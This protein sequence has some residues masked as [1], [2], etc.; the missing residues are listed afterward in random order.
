[1]VQNQSRA[2]Q[3]PQSHLKESDPERAVIRVMHSA[4]CHAGF[5]AFVRSVLSRRSPFCTSKAGRA[6]TT[7]PRRTL[8]VSA[9][10]RV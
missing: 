4:Q 1:M 6:P 5:V 2:E 10:V 3:I 9:I 8:R 7:P